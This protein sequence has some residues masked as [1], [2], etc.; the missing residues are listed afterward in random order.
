MHNSTKC[1]RAQLQEN[2]WPYPTISITVG[3]AEET[4]DL[5][6]ENDGGLSNCVYCTR[7]VPRNDDKRLFCKEA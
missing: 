5:Q 6:C 4:A 7:S 2:P 1:A 3:M